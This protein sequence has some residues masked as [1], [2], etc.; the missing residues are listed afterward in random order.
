LESACGIFLPLWLTYFQTLLTKAIGSQKQHTI[1]LIDTPGHADFTF[2]VIRSLRVLDGAICIL[3]G[4]AGVEAQTERV[5]HQASIHRIPRI[6]YVNK[7]DRDGAAFE[8][9]VKEIASRLHT[10]PIL[11]QIPWFM[12]GRFVGIGD[13]INL[14]GLLWDHGGS[15]AIFQTYTYSTLQEIDSIFANEVRKARIALLEVLAEYDDKM[16]EEFLEADEDWLRIKP[17]TIRE[18]LRKCLLSTAQAVTPVF[19]GASFRNIGVQPVLDA[20]NYLLPSPRE[21]PD[22]DINLEGSDSSLSELL[23]GETDMKQSSKSTGRRAVSPLPSKSMAMAQNLSGCAL[24][25]KVVNDTRRGVLVY[26]RVYSG[27]IT[28]NALLYNT[29]LAITERIPRL[30]RMYASDAVEIDSIEEGQIGVITGLKHART[31]D[32]LM[33]YAGTS[34]KNP[35]PPPINSLQLRPITVPPPLFFTSVEP[36]S[37]AEEKTIADTLALLLREDPSLS[38]SVDPE[39]GQTH[40]A[41]MG[42]LHLEIARDRLINDFKAKASTGKIEIGYRE[43]ITGLSPDCTETFDREIAGKR[44]E[45]SCT[46]SVDV[47]DSS[48]DIV[49]SDDGH[50]QLLTLADSNYLVVHH[51]TLYNTGKPTPGCTSLPPFLPLP[52]IC[53]A[54]KTGTTAAL[55]RG[56]THRLPLHSTHINIT[57]DPAAHITSTTTPAA[58]SSAAR[59]ATR[60]ALKASASRAD[61][62]LLE[63]VMLATITVPEDALGGVVHDLSAARGAQVLSLDADNPMAEDNEDVAQKRLSEEQLR[64]VYVPKD[65]F[66]KREGVEEVGSVSQQRQIRARVPLKEMVGYLKHLRSLTGGRGTFVMS[67]DRFERMSSQRMKVALA[68]MRGSYV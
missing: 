5:W 52:T 25:F 47:L 66:G 32:T 40:L 57:F 61:T 44:A 43:A 14:T 27:S 12:D 10:W 28:R 8:K 19:A 2:E 63:P 36:N 4:V 11:C 34:P 22:P 50:T 35:P 55:S 56:P 16:V 31:G 68:E 64:R 39:S 6:I 60:A 30:L 53:A 46:A 21:A 24:A 42:E 1:N 26:V 38:V 58:L 45:A 18:S 65:P 9:T 7:L 13:P 59:L 23:H 33:V 29:N 37:L 20:V 3:D 62:I 51:P 41:G 67:V 54:L 15:G 48:S 17:E 49:V